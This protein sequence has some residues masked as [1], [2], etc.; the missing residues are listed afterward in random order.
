MKEDYRKLD[1]QQLSNEIQKKTQE[2]IELRNELARRTGERL[3][4]YNYDFTK[5]VTD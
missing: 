3:P 2:L 5:R 4:I 1:N